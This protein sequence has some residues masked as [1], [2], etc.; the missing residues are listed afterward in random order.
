MKKEIIILLS[1]TLLA[2]CG[3]GGGGNESGGSNTFAET[4]PGL[5]STVS[6][7]TVANGAIAYQQY[8][9]GPLELQKNQWL[10]IPGVPL[11]IVNSTVEFNGT[12]GSGSIQFSLFGATQRIE[13][14][15]R[16]ANSRWTGSLSAGAI[17]LEGNA[18]LGCDLDAASPIEKTQL[19]V[20]T[21]LERVANMKEIDEVWGKSFTVQECGT[22]GVVGLA[23]VNINSDGSSS[24]DLFKNPPTSN[25]SLSRDELITLLQMN[26]YGGGVNLNGVFVGNGR[27]SGHLYRYTRNG[28]PRHAIVVRHYRTVPTPKSSDYLLLQK[29]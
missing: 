7:A 8:Y 24:W 18:L 11:P 21:S 5:Q 10:P 4:V 23:D 2:A 25:G 28:A 22:A 12:S 3:G 14:S 27:A 16:Y 1:S 17:Y 29:G 6:S 15:D 19:F 13:T 26:T 20:S 9:S